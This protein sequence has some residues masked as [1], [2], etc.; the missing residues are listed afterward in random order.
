MQS[1]KVSSEPRSEVGIDPL[2]QPDV[3]SFF[4]AVLFNAVLMG[5]VTQSYCCH[6][7]FWDGN[8]VRL[9]RDR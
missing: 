1:W 9:I 7:R 8:E 3:T 4:D 2:G 5:R 6:L